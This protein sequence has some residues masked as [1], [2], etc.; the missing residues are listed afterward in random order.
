MFTRLQQK[1]SGRKGSGHVFCRVCA[2]C[3]ISRRVGLSILFWGHSTQ[4][5]VL[6]PPQVLGKLPVVQHLKFGT[7]LKWDSEF[8]D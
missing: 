7:L 8:E 2:R 5:N 3:R 6:S 4:F 1:S